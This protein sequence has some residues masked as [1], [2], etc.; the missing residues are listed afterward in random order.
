M[1]SRIILLLCFI[2]TLGFTAQAQDYTYSAAQR[3]EAWAQFDM[4]MRCYKSRNYSKAVQWFTRAGNQGH[5]D[6]QHY[7]GVCYAAGQGVAKNYRMAADWYVKAARQGHSDSQYALALRLGKML[8]NIA[9]TKRGCA[10]WRT[11]FWCP[12]RESNP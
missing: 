6:A 5:A 4:G 8:C 10:D 1:K 9:G 11:L 3:G 12:Q 7:M 2:F